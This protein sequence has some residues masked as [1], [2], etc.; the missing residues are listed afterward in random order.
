MFCKRKK[1]IYIDQ[2]KKAE[3]NRSERG[4]ITRVYRN[5]GNTVKSAFYKVK[6]QIR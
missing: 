6:Y 5:K 4:D 2:E 3:I 1:I